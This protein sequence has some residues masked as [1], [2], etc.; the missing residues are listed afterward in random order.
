MAD[1]GFLVGSVPGCD[2]RLP[3]T[4]LPPVLCLISRS[5]EGVFLRK[6]APAQPVL[7]NGRPVS[8]TPL[9]DGDRVTLGAVDLLVH[10]ATLP[11]SESKIQSSSFGTEPDSKTVALRAEVEKKQKELAE[12]TRELETDR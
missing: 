4:A 3:G 5:P 12:Q 6:L 8:A 11:S 7:V 1:V 10:I 9:N 2:L